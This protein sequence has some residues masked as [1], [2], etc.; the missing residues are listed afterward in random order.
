MKSEFVD[1]SIGAMKIVPPA[2]VA[3]A[4]QVGRIEPQNIL[5]WLSIVYTIGLLVQL[6]S[7]NGHRWVRFVIRC[8]AWLRRKFRRE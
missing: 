3:A 1:F 7:N 8:L 5:I 6:L 4:A 2:A